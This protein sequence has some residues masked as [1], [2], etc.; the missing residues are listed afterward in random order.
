MNSIARAH[1]SPI[2]KQKYYEFMAKKDEFERAYHARSNVEAV[3]SAIK[4]KLGE[5]L[6]SHNVA[7][8]FNELL[9]R[10]VAY[11]IG[12]IVHEIHEHG[13][14]PRVPGGSGATPVEALPTSEDVPCEFNRAPGKEVLD[15]RAEP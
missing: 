2:W 15:S 4:R 3:N 1:S 6:L 13:I 14:D 11:N 9:A 10:L 5:P 8:R 7:A 12:V